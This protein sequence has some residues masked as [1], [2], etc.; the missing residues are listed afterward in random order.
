VFA[1]SLG[2]TQRLPR[3]V[4]TA[5]AKE[6]IFTGRVLSG[7]EAYD[8]GLVNDV[9]EQNESETGAFEQAI[10]LAEEILPQGPI[11]LRMAKKA[12][13]Q[14]IQVDLTSG[15]KF[16]ENCYAQIIPTKD[17]LEGLRAFKEKR[18]PVYKG[19]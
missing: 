4:G 16:E 3:L 13:N 9:V 14:G 5:K 7:R 8:V 10:K 17:R 11:A 18:K 2:G 12:I 15:L 6:L 19:E 1:T